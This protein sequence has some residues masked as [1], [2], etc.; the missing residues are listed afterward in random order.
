MRIGDSDEPHTICPASC[1]TGPA[2]RSWRRT[3]TMKTCLAHIY[4]VRY[5]LLRRHN[6]LIVFELATRATQLIAIAVA[7]ACSCCVLPH[8]RP[9]N[10]AANGVALMAVLDPSARTGRRFGRPRSLISSCS[11]SGRRCIG[12]H[13]N[14]NSR[15]TPGGALHARRERTRERD[16]EQLPRHQVTGWVLE[17]VAAAL[18]R[19][20]HRARGLLL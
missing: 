6:N 19:R 5:R 4:K 7:N 13:L 12:S 20:R 15:A 2:N 16:E 10:S 8:P 1:E 18:R 11:L 17:R 9:S 3:S 14:S